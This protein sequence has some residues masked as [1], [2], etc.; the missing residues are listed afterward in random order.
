MLEEQGDT[1]RAKQ[2]WTEARKLLPPDSGQ[3]SWIEEHARRLDVFATVSAPRPAP[4]K[5]VGRLAPL[6]P[7]AIALSKGK[8]L[9]AIFNLKFI[10][11]L[12]AF[13]GV[14][15]SSYGMAFGLGLTVQILIH[16]LGHYIDI[17][18]RG[19]PAD[20]PVFLPGLGAFVRW[21]AM[22]VPL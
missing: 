21:Q 7:I 11:S 19:L 20:M 18:R 22:G 15:W 14:Y 2:Q 6:A 1:A 16:E 9:L 12:G 3:A 13:L 5:W 17:R 8:A 10:F 4:S